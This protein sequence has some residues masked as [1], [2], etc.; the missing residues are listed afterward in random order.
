MTDVLVRKLE[1]VIQSIF[2]GEGVVDVAGV[3]YAKDTVCRAPVSHNCFQHIPV[4][5]LWYACIPAPIWDGDL[6]GIQFR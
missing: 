3:F 4:S 2:H 6:C 1:E 5:L